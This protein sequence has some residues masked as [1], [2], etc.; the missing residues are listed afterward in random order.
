MPATSA[1][2]LKQVWRLAHVLFCT[3]LHIFSPL[4]GHKWCTLWCKDR[5]SHYNS[6]IFF[7]CFFCYFFFPSD[8]FQL[9][10]CMRDI[11]FPSHAQLMGVYAW[12]E[13]KIHKVLQPE[14]HRLM[15]WEMDNLQMAFTPLKYVEELGKDCVSDS[16][17]AWQKPQYN[18]GMFFSD[19]CQMLI[20]ETNGH[21]PKMS[22]FISDLIML[23]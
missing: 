9:Y 2:T 14:L 6:F 18:L 10:G 7:R 13:H 5:V 3:F 12:M 16:Q 4:W 19:S 17:T 11:S 20:R 1:M 8:F 22:V 21:S 23:T 15:I